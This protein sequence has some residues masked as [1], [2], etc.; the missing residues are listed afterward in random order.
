M[1]EEKTVEEWTEI[2]NN[3]A[4]GNWEHVLFMSPHILEKLI[5]QKAPLENFMGWW[6]VSK[7]L[8]LTTAKK[9]NIFY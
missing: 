5:E 1:K 7:R 6:A 8:S 9:Y 3:A 4:I 2:L